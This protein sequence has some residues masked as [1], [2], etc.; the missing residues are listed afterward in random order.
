MLLVDILELKGV[1][2][3][4]KAGEI[5]LV[6]RGHGRLGGYNGI[7]LL[8]NGV[9]HWTRS[10]AHVLVDLELVGNAGGSGHK[11]HR[12]NSTA[13]RANGRQF[14]GC[15]GDD[16][17]KHHAVGIAGSLTVVL[18]AANGIDD[19]LAVHIC[20]IDDALSLLASIGDGL[21]GLSSGLHRQYAGQ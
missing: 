10:R 14:A 13:V 16:V 4:A 19:V 12:L 3:I 8:R 7:G 20:A 1:L 6:R 2:S 21:A 9:V 5:L 17:L 18:Q 15:I 11:V